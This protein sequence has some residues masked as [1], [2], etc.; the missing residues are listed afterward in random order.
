MEKNLIQGARKIDTFG[1]FLVAS[2]F[3]YKVFELFRAYG[4]FVPVHF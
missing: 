1:K 3:K 2:Y 4:N